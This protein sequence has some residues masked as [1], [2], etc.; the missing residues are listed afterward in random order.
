MNKIKKEHFIELL[1]S[2]T[3]HQLK[4]F[5]SYLQS[6][7]LCGDSNVI[8]LF[9]RIQ[10][11]LKSGKVQQSAMSKS[12]KKYHYPN[13]QNKFSSFLALELTNEHHLTCSI[14]QLKALSFFNHSSLYDRQYNQLHKVYSSIKTIKDQYQLHQLHLIHFDIKAKEGNIKMLPNFSDVVN[15]FDL[16]FLLERLRL[17]CA[18]LNLKKVVNTGPIEITAAYIIQQAQHFHSHPLM[19]VYLSIYHMLIEENAVTHY[20]LLTSR[21]A[22]TISKQPIN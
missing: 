2:C 16:H 11:G 20:K 18:Y 22:E 6:Y 4:K 10:K 12:E 21:L 14:N 7:Y 1:N 8:K 19:Q 13:L 17:T 9:N 15:S 3:Q 5:T